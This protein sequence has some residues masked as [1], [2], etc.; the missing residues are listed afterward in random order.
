[1][2]SN[3]K[4]KK[5]GL[6][7]THVRIQTTHSTEQRR[8]ENRETHTQTQIQKTE[9]P[10]HEHRYSYKK[11]QTLHRQRFHSTKQMDSAN[12]KGGACEQ[13][14]SDRYVGADPSLLDRYWSGSPKKSQD[15][16]DLHQN[17]ELLFQ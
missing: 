9:K 7:T 15:L 16:V 2:E 13:T 1:M 14:N 5:C 4:S 6:F 10:I 8:T 12:D 11:T 3:S 17:L